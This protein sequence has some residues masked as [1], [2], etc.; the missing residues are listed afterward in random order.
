[1]EAVLDTTPLPTPCTSLF[2]TESHTSDRFCLSIREK[3]SSFPQRKLV[4]DLEKLSTESCLFW[5]P[6]CYPFQKHLDSLHFY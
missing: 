6:L 3:K 5:T 4:C 1:M 2:S